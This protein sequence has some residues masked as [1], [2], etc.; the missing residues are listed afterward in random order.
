M[1]IA[2]AG[3]GI[4]KARGWC[5]LIHAWWHPLV[6][7]ARLANPPIHDTPQNYLIGMT[8]NFVKALQWSTTRFILCFGVYAHKPSMY[9]MMA[10]IKIFL[11]NF[12]IIFLLLN[13]INYSRKHKCFPTTEI[14]FKLLRLLSNYKY[15]YFTNKLLSWC[16]QT[17]TILIS[18]TIA[19]NSKVHLQIL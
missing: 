12:S 2:C 9:G 14:T 1:R 7:D 3:S 19:T 13:Y 16:T 8:K 5:P 17:I 18:N 15:S 6:P 11:V 4:W 10:R